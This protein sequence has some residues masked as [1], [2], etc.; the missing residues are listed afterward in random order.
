MNAVLCTARVSVRR[1]PAGAW[2]GRVGNKVGRRQ[3]ADHE[4]RRSAYGRVRRRN[5]RE[6]VPDAQTAGRSMRL[7]VWCVAWPNH[8]RRGLRVLRG[9]PAASTSNPT[10]RKWPSVAITVRSLSSRITA[11]LVQSVND[12]SLSRYWKNRCR[13]RSKRSLSIRSHRSRALPSICCHQAFDA[14]SP[15]R[16]QISVSVSPTTKSVVITWAQ[17]QMPAD[18]VQYLAVDAQSRTIAIW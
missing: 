4:R 16:N 8:E 5:R 7:T 13:A 10:W 18:L 15:R 11:M 6:Q 1:L 14:A 12:R 3:D 9:R 2:T 17:Y